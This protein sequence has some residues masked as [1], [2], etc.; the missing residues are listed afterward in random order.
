MGCH[1]APQA[2]AIGTGQRPVVVALAG[3][4]NVGKSSLFNALTGLRQ[5]VG[6]WPGKTVERREGSLDLGGRTALLV[7]LPGSYS[8]E[9][10]TLEES[11]TRQF[12]V[13][14]RPDVIVDVVDALHLERNLY[15]TSQLL[16][17]G[18]PTFVALTMGD[19]ARAL[20]VE[21]DVDALARRLGVP[22]VPVVAA[23][24]E[25]LDV[26]RRT[27]ESAVAGGVAAP[28][29]PVYPDSTLEA[30]V[31]SLLREIPCDHPVA[32]R[33]LALGFIQQDPGTIRDLEAVLPEAERERLRR[34]V[35]AAAP[36]G[37]V[38]VAD[39]RYAWV[40]AV[41]RE[42]LRER[43]AGRP[44]RGT[45]ARLA[46]RV[47]LVVTHPVVGP[48]LT[49]A[50]LAAG[51]WSAFQIAA[52]LQEWLDG[53]FAWLSVSVAGAL[54]GRVAPWTL[55]LLTDGVLAGVATVA[56][57]APLIAAF[58]LFLGL[59]EDS[60]YF[61]RAA[62][63]L[64]RL[65]SRFGLHGKA[66]I[67]LFIGYGCNVP[68]VM[69][70]RTASSR[71]ARLVSVLVSPLVICSA[72]L[73]VIG[74]MAGV[75]FPG[76][77]AAWVMAGL[78]AVGLVLVLSVAWLLSRTLLRGDEEPFLIEL[79]PYRMPRL[80]NVAV[81]AWQQTAHFL[82]RAVTVIAPMTAVVWA[83]AYFPSGSVESSFAAWLG[84]L[85]EPLGRPLGFDW[86]M[87]VSL[88][89]GFL[90]KEASLP[91][92]AV[93]YA[94]GADQ[95]LGAALRAALTV[96]QAL[97]YLVFYTFY[98]PCLATAVTIRQEIGSTRWTLVSVG[99]SLLLAGGLAWVAHWGALQLWA[100]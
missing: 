14:E 10:Y 56:L 68:A 91:T 81:Y 34:A 65:L 12:L 27:L 64:D 44:L 51:I 31:A 41:V 90:A 23:T 85:L 16:E 63:V 92:L 42:A 60:G 78:Y 52:P 48:P 100:A 93:L 15:L 19:M 5:R 38:R 59:L 45:P 33:R 94:A 3:N 29:P 25:G 71:T 13:E 40:A 18:I 69:A 73:V 83:I 17:L 62:F 76:S 50:T 21:I 82:Q 72:R 87:I 95:G 86:R 49:A 67:G 54:T 97:S 39:A 24:G 32:G 30:L 4:P 77:G 88:F 66:G 46:D 47:D 36:D 55:A 53:L 89:P 70:A 8:L 75:F 98:T 61:A 26:L 7:D 43:V 6:N 28:S 9:S 96:P 57:F 20:G 11:V 22:V 84:H 74:F 58:F 35:E 1:V 79:P 80:R 2:V 99:Y 37:P